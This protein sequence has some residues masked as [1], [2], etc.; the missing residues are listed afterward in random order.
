M[1]PYANMK[2][3]MVETVDGKSL[4]QESSSSCIDLGAGIWSTTNIGLLWANTT[5]SFRA[6]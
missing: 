5:S 6:V 2:I 1:N 3:P 4:T